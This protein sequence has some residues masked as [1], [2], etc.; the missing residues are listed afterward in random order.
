MLY[1][2]D[3]VCTMMVDEKKSQHISEVNWKKVYLC[4]AYCK[5]QFDQNR[6]KYGS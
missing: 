1:D 2:K 5:S 6:Q 4:S 3:A